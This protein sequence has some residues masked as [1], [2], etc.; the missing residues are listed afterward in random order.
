MTPLLLMTAAR[1]YRQNCDQL[2]RGPI[3]H[4]QLE[5]QHGGLD[6]GDNGQKEVRQKSVCE[7]ES[8]DPY[9]PNQQFL[10]LVEVAQAE[11]GL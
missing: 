11:N 5:M 1:L 4:R 3:P 9:N 7:K 8:S 2:D 6:D 10:W